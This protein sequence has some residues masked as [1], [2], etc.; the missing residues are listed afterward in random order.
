MARIYPLALGKNTEFFYLSTG[1]RH[2]LRHQYRDSLR[3]IREENLIIGD[4]PRATWVIERSSDGQ[5]GNSFHGTE[6]IWIDKQLGITLKRELGGS[7]LG[8]RIRAYT[9]SQG[10]F[11]IRS[12]HHRCPERFTVVRWQFRDFG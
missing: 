5:S 6:T 11:N 9:V 7:N 10:G 4:A 2:G 1:T 3:V 8:E 12:E